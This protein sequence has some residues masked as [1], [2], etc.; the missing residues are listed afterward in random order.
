MSSSPSTHTPASTLT[1]VP[2][3]Y[4]HP[5]AWA[6]VSA[7]HADQLT[8]YGRADDP[9]DTTP[10]E[11]LPPAGLFLVGYHDAQPVAC[12]GLRSLDPASRTA[13]IKRMFVAPD[14]RGRGYGRRV[15][16]SLEDAAR[17]GGARRIILETGARNLEAL[18][19]YQQ[20]GYQPI[21]PYTD[22]RNPTVNRAF[23]K[24]P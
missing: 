12:G 15:L 3:R 10:E 5:D 1:L 8:R 22:G 23:A 6:L 2:R 11:F 18:A 13:E 9:T 21:P 20:A 16:A 14:H 24:D 19:L 4:D 7:L 17:T